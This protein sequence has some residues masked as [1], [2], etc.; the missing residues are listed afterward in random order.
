[1]RFCRVAPLFVAL[2][3][4]VASAGSTTDQ[5][6]VL[7]AGAL[8]DTQSSEIR[9]NVSIVVK[10]GWVTAVGVSPEV[11]SGARVLD[12]TGLT[13]VPGLIDAHTYLCESIPVAGDVGGAF[14]VH[15][16]RETTTDRALQ[17]VA[18][19]RSFLEAGFTTVRDVGNCGDWGD[20][21]LKRAIERGLVEGPTMFVS[22]K[23][24]APMGG[25]MQLTP[26]HPDLAAI[27]YLE[28]DSH[29]QMRAAV[30]RNLHYGADWIRIVVDDQRYL[31]SEDDIGFIVKEAAGAGVR[32]AA[33]CMSDEAA[34]RAIEAGVAS[35]EHGFFV[36]E[37]SLRSAAEHGVWLVGTDF[38][39]EILAVY[40][41]PEWYQAVV[42][43]LR[44]AYRLGVPLAFGSDIVIEVPG[45]DRGSAVLTLLDTWR[46]AGV[47][48]PAILKAMTVDAARLLGIGRTRGT[49][50][51]GM[52]AD[53]FAVKGNPLED[54]TALRHAVL[55]MK[56]GRVVMDRR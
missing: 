42:K 48:P 50:R 55:V 14:T 20:I 11:P 36:K 54:I 47:P 33:H 10:D 9:R 3:L 16:I 6:T 51:P 43:R 34:M 52:A 40:R 25:Q 41:K 56:H 19:A 8:V 39:R 21:A 45:H 35:I 15:L 4:L 44:E 24:I 31:Y 7:R 53:L 38:S 32:V 22:G 29:N 27:D 26:E 17:G 23:I 5:V 46:D 2:P 30:R 12:L 49:I 18:N 37:R 28:A 13:V 1:M